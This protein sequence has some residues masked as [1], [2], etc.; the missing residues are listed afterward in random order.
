MTWT[1]SFLDGSEPVTGLAEE[2]QAICLAE[3]YDAIH[4]AGENLAVVSED[5]TTN[6]ETKVQR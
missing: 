3:G 6:D 1:V 4:G 2:W 5:E